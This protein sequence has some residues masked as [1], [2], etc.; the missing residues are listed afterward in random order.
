MCWKEAHIPLASAYMAN[1][2]ATCHNGN[3]NATPNTCDGCHIDNYNQTT[4]PNH[5]ASQFAT[6]CQDCHT[7]TA[8][9]PSTFD[10]NSAYPL[11]EALTTIAAIVC[12]VTPTDQ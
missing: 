4:N 8:W 2:C 3:Y 11:T 5:V 6:T 9:V 10:H 1:Q 12:S 7:Q